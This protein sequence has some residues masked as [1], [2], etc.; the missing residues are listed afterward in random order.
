[1]FTKINVE[2]FKLRSFEKSQMETHDVDCVQMIC[3]IVQ[4]DEGVICD[5]CINFHV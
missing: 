4:S 2:V 3:D 1:M 5:Q